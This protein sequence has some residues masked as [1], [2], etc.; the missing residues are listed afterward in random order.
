M[1]IQKSI[2]ILISVATLFACNN[3]TSKSVSNKKEV[4]S[5]VVQPS[6]AEVILNQAINAHGGDLYDSANYTF[7]FRGNT[8]QFKNDGKAY[9]Y[10][11]SSQ[12]GD[13]LIIDRLK[14][15]KFSRTINND[16]IALSEKDIKSGTGA[17][18][19]VIYFATLPHKLKDD[20]VNETYMGET[21]IKGKNYS[22]LSIS[23]SQDGGGEDF[24]DEYY[25]W[26][27]TDAHTV[28]YLAYNFH[29]NQGGVRFRSAY[30]RSIVDGITFQDYVNY[31]AEVGTPLKALPELY[32]A[33]K[34]IELSKIETESITNLNAN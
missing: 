33:G 34:L 1:G 32:E 5:E 18:N 29:V 30:N 26:I 22:I 9:E 12:K 10:S 4:V 28:D 6:K 17:I 7:V 11:K 21:T 16:T 23:F 20:A 19:S 3:T 25:Y 13:S 15:G 31:K 14:N 8:Y 2:L 24:D 27:D